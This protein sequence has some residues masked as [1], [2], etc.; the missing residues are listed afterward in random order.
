MIWFFFSSSLACRFS[1]WHNIL[2]VT[3]RNYGFAHICCDSVAPLISGKKCLL[4]QTSRFV[5]FFVWFLFFLIF[6]FVFLNVNRCNIY[7]YFLSS[8]LI[9]ALSIHKIILTS[10]IDQCIPSQCVFKALDPVWLG[11]RYVVCIKHCCEGFEGSN[12]CSLSECS[13]SRIKCWA[14]ISVRLAHQFL[15]ILSCLPARPPAWEPETLDE[16]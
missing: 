14:S 16:N 15:P 5:G 3:W 10:Y 13:C 2:F 12:D 9:K 1:M 7:S 4:N 8:L 11:E 6:F